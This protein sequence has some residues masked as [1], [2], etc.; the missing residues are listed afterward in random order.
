LFFSLLILQVDD[1]EGDSRKYGKMM[2]VFF[3]MVVF[4][5]F[6]SAKLRL[7]YF[8]SYVRMLRKYSS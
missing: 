3:M 1:V 8:C 4:S 5:G 6:A 7:F 2:A